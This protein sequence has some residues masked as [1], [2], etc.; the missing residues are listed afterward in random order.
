M[1]FNIKSFIAGMLLMLA[2]M[3]TGI[4]IYTVSG[5]FKSVEYK[6]NKIIAVS[7]GIKSAEYNENKVIFNGDEIDISS[8]PMIT[9]VKVKETYGSNYMPVRKIL[10]ELGYGVGWD[11]EHQSILIFTEEYLENSIEWVDYDTVIKTIG[12]IEDKERSDNVAQHIDFI[13]EWQTIHA[14]YDSKHSWDIPTVVIN[15]K[16]Y[17]S[18]DSI[19]NFYNLYN[20]PLILT[21]SEIE[22]NKILQKEY[23]DSLNASIA[24]DEV[25]NKLLR[26]F[27]SNGD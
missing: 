23:Q 8:F 14:S 3:I 25:L 22:Y 27:F 24:V 19:N 11:G 5:G 9:V 21:P 16:V 4:Y 10:T 17:V 26:T 12:D 2:L 7:D 1:K 6:E 18:R 15:G 20:I 13:E